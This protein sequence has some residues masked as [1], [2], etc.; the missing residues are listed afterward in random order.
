MNVSKRLFPYKLNFDAISV[1][2][3]NDL[4]IDCF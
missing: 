1:K 4:L 2:L 3:F